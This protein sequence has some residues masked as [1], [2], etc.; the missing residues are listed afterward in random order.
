MR[1]L[2][3]SVHTAPRKT[4]GAQSTQLWLLRFLAAGLICC[5]LALP[6]TGVAATRTKTLT[7]IKTLTRTRTPTRTPTVRPTLAATSTPTASVTA[8]PTNAP[9]ATPTTKP[10]QT[11]APTITRPA[12]ATATATPIPTATTTSTTADN[13]TPTPSATPTSPGLTNCPVAGATLAMQVDNRTG[14]PQPVTFTGT[15]VAA[16]CSGGTTSFTASA[17]CDAG[18]TNCLTVPGLASGIWKHAISVGAQDQ[19]QKSLIVAGDPNGVA[20]MISWVVF[21]TVLTVDRTDDVSSNPTPQ[22]PSAPGSRTCTLR[23]ALS[24]G[25]TAAAPLLVQFD[26][27][28]FPA[29]VPTA[30]RLS[31]TDSLPIA[32]YE[33]TVDGTDANGD[34]TF[35][36]DPYNRIIELPSSGATF[37]FSNQ[38]AH[39]VGLFLQR[40]SLLDGATPADIIRFDGSGGRTEQNALRNCKIDGGAS[41]LTTKSTAHD[42]VDA[43]AGAGTDWNTANVVENCELTACPDKGAKSTTLA[44]LAVRDSWVHH[45]IGGGI[46]A[47]LSGNVQADRNV[48]E[49]NGYNATAQVFAS[50]NGLAANGANGA[51]QPTTP[52][53]PSVLQTSGNI[54]RNNSSRGISV[55][56]VSTAIIMND[57]SCGASNS[58][59]GGQN[60]IAI[61][62]TTTSPASAI[63][64][65]T[66]T[67]YNG[68]NGVTV[69]NQSSGDFGQNSP[70]GGHNAFTQNATNPSLGGH[71]FDNSSTQ[72]NLPALNNQW[73]H[74]YANPTQPGT[75]CDGNIIVDISGSASVVPPESYR[76]DTNT[77]PVSIQS[78]S[79]TKA[80]AG[81]LV[82]ITG[83]GFNAIDGYPAGGN[84][85]TTIAENN[86]C[87]GAIVGTCVQYETS[88]GMWEDLPVQSVTPAEIVVQLPAD[89]TCSQ[90]VNVRVQRLDYTGAVVSATKAF[91][92]NS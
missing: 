28:V 34:P 31:Q 45:N 85:T 36:G 90:P 59:T 64:R 42:C 37:V 62:N 52:T 29:G 87:N 91:C 7:R 43:C 61:Y 18:L 80:S 21:Q 86:T 38:R 4:I 76:G 89:I 24:A 2:L 9:T 27:A 72:A 26:P 1:L 81:D 75:T 22:C 71:N 16:S 74:C 57:F 40:P 56:E 10:T 23:Q 6:A 12:T 51:V 60:G 39:V 53:T 55:Q 73:Q 11:S 70:D 15:L 50:A 65:G 8:T 68:R 63:V 82:H 44:Y 58:G 14:L 17:V 5:A 66:A 92:T 79:P 77:L 69:A 20:N 83:G 54:I 84:C 13:P 49:Y 67:V 32:G 19:Y 47:T 41:A 78:F 88:P 3:L 30:I 48:V 25:A 46:Q 33:M 35:R